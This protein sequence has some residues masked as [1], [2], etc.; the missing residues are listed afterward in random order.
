MCMAKH[1]IYN[2][3][4]LLLSANPILNETWRNID[5]EKYHFLS[6]CNLCRYARF[7]QAQ[8][9][10]LYRNLGCTENL[11]ASAIIHKSAALITT[12]DLVLLIVE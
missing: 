11:S 5:Q 2:I 6:M 3:I 1:I 12:K 9:H 8:S 7:L 4:K 10:K